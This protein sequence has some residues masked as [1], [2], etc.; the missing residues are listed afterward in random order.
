MYVFRLS[1]LLIP[2]LLSSCVDELSETLDEAAQK[3]L[4]ASDSSTNNML[5][6]DD[7]VEVESTEDGLSITLRAINSQEDGTF[8]WTGGSLVLENEYQIAIP[9]ELSVTKGSISSLDG[10]YLIIDNIYCFYRV[11]DKKSL[12]LSNCYNNDSS[13]EYS[14]DV[15]LNANERVLLQAEGDSEDTG[16]V[17]IEAELTASLVS[18]EESAEDELAEEQEEEGEEEVASVDE[19]EVIV[20]EDDE[21]TDEEEVSEEIEI[22]EEEKEDESEVIGDDVAECILSLPAYK[23]VAFFEEGMIP[24]CKISSKERIAKILSH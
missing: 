22:V 19:D 3:S 4:E 12:V 17:Y 7:L 20:V 2:L 23:Q 18:E 15:L 16:I 11:D 14:S 9:E 6:E 24:N 10:L 5:K 21:E 13:N 1:L 8:F